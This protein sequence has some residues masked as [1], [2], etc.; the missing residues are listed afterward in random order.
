MLAFLADPFEPKVSSDRC[1]LRRNRG[2][3]QMR[4]ETGRFFLGVSSSS[5]ILCRHHG[6][7][8]RFEPWQELAFGGCDPELQRWKGKKGSTWQK[9]S[10][11][12]QKGVAHS[13]G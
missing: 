12:S 6:L 5:P 9:T 4:A 8:S 11:V 7:F 2:H 3:W 10:P 1:P 13:F